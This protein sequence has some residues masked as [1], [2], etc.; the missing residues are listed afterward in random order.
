MLLN[1]FGLFPL[2]IELLLPV[3]KGFPF[4]E[5][6]KSVFEGV[7]FP[8]FPVPPVLLDKVDPEFNLVL[9][10][11]LLFGVFAEVSIEDTEF[12]LKLIEFKLL[13]VGL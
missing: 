11:K 3:K 2:I 5:G 10:I 12:L 7:K 4:W 9:F 1:V 13:A 8:T 6:L